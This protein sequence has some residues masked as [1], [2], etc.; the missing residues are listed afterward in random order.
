MPLRRF[1][2]LRAQEF[3]DK[4]YPLSKAMRA[5]GTSLRD[6]P[7]IPKDAITAAKSF[8]R[9]AYQAQG[10]YKPRPKRRKITPM[11]HPKLALVSITAKC[12]YACLVDQILSGNVANG[13]LD[14][15]LRTLKTYYG[16]RTS[17]SAARNA[18]KELLSV[19]LIECTKSKPHSKW[20]RY[21]ILLTDRPG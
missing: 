6:Q 19:G 8:V 17:P 13:E 1:I 14:A 12:L 21:R 16:W 20:A 11:Q 15:T 18:R 7:H 10:R 3:L 5:I 2:E 9:A 4:R